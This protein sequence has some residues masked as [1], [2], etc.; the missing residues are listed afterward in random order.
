MTNPDHSPR[1]TTREKRERKAERLRSWA[2]AREAKQL[3]LNEAARADEAA[4]GIPF[5]Q[6]ILVGHHS[7]RRHR[8]AIERIDRNM[9]AAVE[10]ARKAEGMAA[11][12]DEIERQADRAI[13]DDDPDAI[14]RLQAKLARLEAEREQR[15]QA[16]AA[17]RREHREALKAMSAYERGQAVPFP[18]YSLSNLSGVITT[19]RQRIERLS[20][21]V[22]AEHGR[23]LIARYPGECRKCGA[24]VARGD[25]VRYF[26]RAKAVECEGCAA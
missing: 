9:R 23:T 4:T 6:P 13:Y 5:G 7:E 16:N 1:L 25:T 11:R 14:E 10:H 18:S 12:A 26:K 2:E 3:T 22:E 19:T 15:K 20:R 17:Y 8:N 24:D 21:P